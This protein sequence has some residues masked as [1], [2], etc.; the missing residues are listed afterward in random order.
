MARAKFLAA[1]ATERISESASR[2]HATLAS[3]SLDRDSCLALLKP[4]E[5]DS[6]NPDKAI[7]GAWP[8]KRPAK[9]NDKDTE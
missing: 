7:S 9:R 8:T 6:F 1:K 5:P 4:V 2:G 3:Q